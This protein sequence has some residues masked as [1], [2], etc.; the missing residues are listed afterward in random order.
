MANEIRELRPRQRRSGN[1][2]EPGP[3]PEFLQ[4]MLERG[5]REI[6]SPFR[7]VTT[8]GT[9][10]AGLFPLRQTGLPLR[11]VV[12]AA[13]AFLAALTPEQR[14]AA[15]FGIEDG[16][17]RAWHNMHTYL[18]RHGALLEKMTG[19]QRE[20]ALDLLRESLSAAG[21]QSARDVMR[22]NHH[23]CEI[24]ERPGEFG[25]WFYWISILG[26][27]SY[28]GPWGWQIDGHHLI[29]NCFVLGDQMVLTPNFM[30][31]EPVYARF[32]KYAG[33]RVFA[34][35]EAR[36]FAVME[37]LGPELRRKATI[38][39]KLPFDVS[40]TAYNDNIE[41]P[42][43]GVRWDELSPVQRDGLLD[44][45]GLYVGRMRPGHAE[46]RI[47]EVKRHIEDTHFAWI[48]AFDDVSPFYYRVHN[49]VILI[50]F[51]HQPGIALDN[52]EPTRHHIHTLVR[53]PNGNDY[54]K[55]LLRQ[56]YQRFDHSTPATPHRLG[57][58]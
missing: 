15:M 36:G 6:A 43:Q 45:I 18:T 4:R 22:L 51:D 30:G 8:D 55:D 16:A 26:T 39:D 5:R 44:L 7:G 11:T 34:A 33:T 49:P 52:D 53:T 2:L 37:A 10:V 35:E 50:E 56:H 9:P 57:L 32:G 40:G 20:R 14:G 31:S 46:V 13:T 48:G 24:T 47:D 19:E 29:V 41:I 23:I 3:L 38:G 27:P 25:E 42:Y 54:G 17:W 21:F 12:D 1:A 58:R 28:D